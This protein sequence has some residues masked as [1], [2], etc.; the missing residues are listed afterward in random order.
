MNAAEID[1]L[2]R[3]YK[4]EQPILHKIKKVRPDR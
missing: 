1:Y 3:Y 4:G 2:W